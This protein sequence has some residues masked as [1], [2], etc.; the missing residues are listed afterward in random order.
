MKAV[1]VFTVFYVTFHADAYCQGG[2]L[3]D[4]DN[5]LSTAMVNCVAQDDKGFIWVGTNNGLNIYDGYRF[6]VYR[7]GDVGCNLGGNTVLCLVQAQYQEGGDVMYL[8]TNSCLQYMQDGRFEDVIADD[9]NPVRGYVKCLYRSPEGKIYCGISAEPGIL[10]IYAKGK[11]RWMVRNNPRIRGI[12][13]I[14]QDVTGTL[15]LTSDRFGLFSVSKNGKGI[16]QFFC[17]ENDRETF[18]CVCADGKGNVFAGSSS[19]LWRYNAS[20][21]FQL[22]SGAAA[23][24]VNRLLAEADGSLLVGTNGD[25]VVRY[26]PSSGTFAPISSESNQLY[27]R[28]ARVGG[29]TRDKEGNLWVCFL[30]KGLYMFGKTDSPFHY[31]GYRKGTDNLINNLCVSAVM[32]SRDG[33]LWLATDGG[34]VFE[35]D[36]D[37]V[38][39]NYFSAPA[40]KTVMGMTEDENGRIWVASYTHGAGMLDR[41]TGAHIPLKGIEDGYHAYN[42][43]ADQR[44]SLWVATMGNGLKKVDLATMAVKSYSAIRYSNCLCNNYINKLSLS[45]DGER[46][47]IST[48]RGVSC[49]DLSNDSWTSV[50]GT[51]S[52]LPDLG[53]SDAKEDAMHRLW[54]CT[55]EGVMLYDIPRNKG[56]EGVRG[57]M[58][59]G[60]SDNT[61]CAV[62]FDDKGNA[63]VSTM[64]GLNKIDVKTLKAERFYVDNGL[65]GNEFCLRVSCAT[66]GYGGKASGNLRLCFGG[67]YGITWFSPSA[68]NYTVHKPQLAV[69]GFSAN[70]VD[71]PV[72]DEIS[73]SH[74]ENNICI[75]LSTFLYSG[76]ER[77]TYLY[78]ID[79]G[80]WKRIPSGEN[81]IALAHMPPGSYRFEIKADNNG[82]ESDIKT[83]EVSISAPWYL[84][85]WALLFYLFMISVAVW[86]YLR[87]L[88]IR[89]ENQL[90]LQRE[91]YAKEMSEQKLQFFINL[92]H[93]IRTPLTLLL[94]PLEQLLKHDHD[95]MQHNLYTAMQR[96]ARRLMNLVDQIMDLRKFDKGQ[97][98]LQFRRTDM[99]GFVQESVDCFT[100]Q[101][102]IKGVTL[103]YIH[104]AERLEA[105]IDRLQF[106]KVIVNILSNAF[107]FTPTGGNI[108]VTVKGDAANCTIEV[109]D[110]GDSIPEAHLPKVFERFY[111]IPGDTGANRNGTGVGLNLALS[112]VELHCGTISVHN[113]SPQGCT[114]VVT[115]P[116]ENAGAVST[117][118]EEETAST[119]AR[120]T[121]DPEPGDSLAGAALSS[122]SSPVSEAPASDSPEAPE[123]RTKGKSTILIAEDEEDI[124]SYLAGALGKTYNVLLCGDGAEA[125]RLTIK[126]M[127]QLIL[128]D[129][130]MPKMDGMQLCAKVKDNINTYHIPVVLL[131]AKTLDE[132]RLSAL[133]LGADAYIQKPFNMDILKSTVANLINT[134]RRLM[135]KANTN[136]SEEQIESPELKSPNEQLMERI[137]ASVNRHLSDEDFSV[138]T[139]ASEVG[140]SRVHLYRKLKE[141]TNLTPH[142]FIRNMRLKRAA[143]LLSEKQ[144]DIM[145]VMY[146]CGFSSLSSFCRLFRA[147]YGSSPKEYMKEH[148]WGIKD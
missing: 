42:V 126:Y 27:I 123:F 10:E 11:A 16:R 80:A 137:T 55:P 4:A 57:E 141:L 15:W 147:A 14:A 109:F 134:R 122:P 85:V 47:Y 69:T 56:G 44:G 114:F 50:F 76:T 91:T 45:P 39:L 97:M 68:V 145:T 112:I 61:S 83:L 108:T 33:H 99:I 70:D 18:P 106:D 92:S 26:T 115:I 127:P 103:N 144:Y 107:K 88:R 135:Q 86:W 30:Q 96:N 87:Q 128:S 72:S 131:T 100:E 63:W 29:M 130:M 1:S 17:D 90:L 81:Q 13:S 95:G 51:N 146:T 143:A 73:L 129:V 138:E 120:L 37:G 84:S 140:I 121:A 31:Q 102:V 142:E 21:G 136:K 5:K 34:G 75:S 98:V 36:E 19:G 28:G 62:E 38:R 22:V 46:L 9:G 113:N 32:F 78:R 6:K 12:Q 82:V 117:E 116:L 64:R 3:F 52:L 49:L 133:D 8:G 104:E 101:A 111:Q 105:C 118:A 41:R 65:Q 77:I 124:R 60:L 66:Q 119:S 89:H 148:L 24:Q 93:D 43:L 20:G 74:D 58:L 7:K 132:D 23:Y 71:L 94:S 35:L 54:V 48:S 79:G 59:H 25:G 139:L 110:D 125:L 40:L 2:K 67:V 53:V